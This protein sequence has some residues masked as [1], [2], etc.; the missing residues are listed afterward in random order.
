MHG[1]LEGIYD[2]NLNEVVVEL[3]RVERVVHGRHHVNDVLRFQ[4]GAL[5]G[6]CRAHFQGP[7]AP[8]ILFEIYFLL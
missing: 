7:I 6:E 8:L 5:R 3:R 2:A 4:P 1:Q